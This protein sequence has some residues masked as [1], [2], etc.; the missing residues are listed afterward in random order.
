MD[1]AL[2]EARALRDESRRVV[3]ALQARY[4]EET[5]ARTLRVKHNNFLGYFIEVPQAVGEELV[6]P[7]L[8]ARFIHRQTMQG[9]MRFSTAELGELEGRIASA[10]DEALARELDCSPTR[11]DAS[12]MGDAIKAAADA[13]AA[14]R[15][16]RGSG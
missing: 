1:P 6:K 2:D 13:L 14:A 3:A 4:A 5:G 10:G 9:A 8:N 7:P 16:R 15:R 12:R 11:R